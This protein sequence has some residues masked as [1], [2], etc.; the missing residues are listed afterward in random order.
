MLDFAQKYYFW[1]RS[2]LTARVFVRLFSLF[3]SIVLYF[4]LCLSC[5]AIARRC[6]ITKYFVCRAFHSTIP[7]ECRRGSNEAQIFWRSRVIS[8]LYSMIVL[9]EN[10]VYFLK[11]LGDARDIR[12][13]LL[14]C[15]ERA[16]SPFISDKERCRL[17]SFVVVGGGPT[18]I[19]Y[20]AELHDF[21]KTDVKRWYPDLQDKVIIRL[22]PPVVLWRDCASKPSLLL[23][24]ESL[25]RKISCSY[26]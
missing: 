15:F 3:C 7:S 18:S 22:R 2:T 9:Q 21:L 23:H 26:A 16:S 19:E 17:L 10:H 14:E 8:P 24:F 20:A 12:N 11:Q 6:N 13:R 25:V 1:P 4:C 5:F